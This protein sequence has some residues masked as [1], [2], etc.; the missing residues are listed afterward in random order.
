MFAWCFRLVTR[1]KK[2]KEI[3]IVCTHECEGCK[4]KRLKAEAELQAQ[5]EKK[6]AAQKGGP[7][8]PGGAG[9]APGASGA[10]QGNQ[11]PDGQGKPAKDN[12][13]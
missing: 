11:P 9:S 1:K 10:R 6:K 8:P 12:P 4:A 13:G 2:K 3:V 5:E 7:K